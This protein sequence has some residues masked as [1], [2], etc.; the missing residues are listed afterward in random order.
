MNCECTLVKFWIFSYDSFSENTW[1]VEVVLLGKPHSME[2]E[3]TSDFPVWG[4]WQ[5]HEISWWHSLHQHTII[6]EGTLWF[7]SRPLRPCS[8]H[9][10]CFLHRVCGCFCLGNK[11]LDIPEEIDKTR[12]LSLSCYYYLDIRDL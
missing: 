3:W 1:M 11:I 7:P 5:T 12:G 2:F 10:C 4:H 8:I 6:S 9:D